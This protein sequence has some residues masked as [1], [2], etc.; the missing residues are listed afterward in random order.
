MSYSPKKQIIIESKNLTGPFSYGD[1]S[2]WFNSAAQGY[3]G[4]TNTINDGIGIVNA[5]STSHAGLPVGKYWI[6]YEV[7]LEVSASGY[8][9]DLTLVSQ[10]SSVTSL[11]PSL[12]WNQFNSNPDIIRGFTEYTIGSS[13]YLRASLK[14]EL[15]VNSIQNHTNFRATLGTAVIDSV[16]YQRI[17][18]TKL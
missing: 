13:D 1:I 12:N 8:G 7:V 16:P 9:N 5:S 11:T 6:D 15:D 10:S 17:I 14:F 4:G 3:T 18:I 2:Y